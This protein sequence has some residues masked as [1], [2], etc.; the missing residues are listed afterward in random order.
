MFSCEWEQV[1]FGEKEG[2]HPYPLYRRN[3]G[4]KEKKSHE[5]LKA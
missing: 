3:L 2:S 1:C 5:I 4:T